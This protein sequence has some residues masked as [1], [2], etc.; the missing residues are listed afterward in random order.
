MLFKSGF[1]LEQK[2]INFIKESDNITLFSAY[3]KLNQLK[4]LNK[5]KNISEIV[6]RWDV[7]DLCIG[8]SDIE[9]Y[10]YC[11]QNNI[12]L[13]RNTRIHLK[14]IW[15]NKDTV[16]FGSAN[17][18]GR[19]IGEK[20]KY[21]YELNSLADNLTIKD[22]VYFKGIIN[23]SELVDDK[24]Y[25]QLLSLKEQFDLKKIEYPKLDTV[26]EHLD[27]FLLSELPMSNSPSYLLNGI[28]DLVDLTNKDKEC[29][30]HDLSLYKIDL[31]LDRKAVE[32][33]LK[34]NFNIHPFILSIKKAIKN[35][36]NNSMRYGGVVQWIQ[37]NTTTV[38]TPRSW[39]M[40]K[41]KIINILYEWICFFDNQFYWNTPKHTQVIHFRKKDKHSI[42]VNLSSFMNNL[43]R[44]SASGEL[45][46]HQVILLA[47]IS[48]LYKKNNSKQISFKK[49]SQEFDLIW[50][51]QNLNFKSTYKSVGMP[52]KAFVNKSLVT[53]KSNQVINNYRNITE[54]I[55][56][57]E[58]IYLED[59]LVILFRE[60]FSEEDILIHL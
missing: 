26:E 42:H 49:L 41:D 16:F 24:L 2:A 43:N 18:T 56:L 31:N 11:K 4:S 54:L 53:L 46:P 1:N 47:A 10:E 48:R 27:E 17:I 23:S 57:I 52:L 58:A 35:T 38:P 19:G 44:D 5:N 40:K 59:T 34:N 37:N 55:N 13:Y 3:I 30:V 51:R 32:E 21:N 50:D 28:F 7:Q 15:N 36:E 60:N 25:G 33:Q 39:E 22:K 14:A 29:L 45:A 12:T 6:V 8:V 20:G 9:L